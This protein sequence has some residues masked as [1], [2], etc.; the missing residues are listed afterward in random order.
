MNNI[1][2]ANCKITEV[3]NIQG[4]KILNKITSIKFCDKHK[5]DSFNLEPI[6]KVEFN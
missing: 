4:T 5:A 3:E 6:R 2:C 1:K